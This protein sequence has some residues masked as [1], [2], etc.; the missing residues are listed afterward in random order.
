MAMMPCGVS[1]VWEQFSRGYPTASPRTLAT[2]SHRYVALRR[3]V[4]YTLRVQERSPPRGGFV[5][6]QN[7]TTKTDG[8]PAAVWLPVSALKPWA[9][10]PRR[11]DAAVQKVAESIKRFGFGAPIVARAAN[12]EVISGHTRL[13]AAK[14]AGL[15]RVPVRLLDVSEEDAR[16]LALADN[17]LGEIAE[18]DL[19]LLADVLSELKA[20]GVDVMA[21]GFDSDELDELIGDAGS[22]AVQT[23]DTSDVR[24]EFWLSVRGPLPQQPDAL[25][26]LR[27][28]LADLPGVTVELGTTEM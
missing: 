4:F 7:E 14:L 20:A 16:L 26:R 21:S 15:D 28:A 17:K 11:N 10:N 5:V 27:A 24:D 13:K 3:A 23:I 19:D 8:Q 12:Y 18:W 6:R 22:V 9:K 1:S 25:E 2:D